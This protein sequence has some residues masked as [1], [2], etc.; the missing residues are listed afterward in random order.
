MGPEEWQRRLARAETTLSRVRSGLGEVF[1][2]WE[3]VRAG[4]GSNHGGIVTTSIERLVG[5]RSLFRMATC[6]LREWPEEGHLYMLEAGASL[7]LPLSPLFTLQRSPESVENACYFYD[8]LE[9]RGVRWI[10]YHFE[11]QPEVVRPGPDVK[12]LIEELNRLG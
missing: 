3:L 5:S 9:A 10:F 11:P 2:G 6:D 4:N 7:P 12:Q 1:D 8:P